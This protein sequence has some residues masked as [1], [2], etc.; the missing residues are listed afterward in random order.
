[1]TPLATPAISAG[2]AALIRRAVDNR[3]L[4]LEAAISKDKD[5]AFQAILNDPRCTIPPDTA[6]R[7]FNELMRANRAVLVGW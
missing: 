6:W 7:M 1:L 5:T 2:L 3:Q 4:T